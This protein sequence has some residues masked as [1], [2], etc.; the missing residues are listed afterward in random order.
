MDRNKAVAGEAKR[1][2]VEAYDSGFETIAYDTIKSAIEKEVT[3]EQIKDAAPEESFPP[4]VKHMLGELDDGKK[5]ALFALTHFLRTVGWSHEA[6]EAKLLEWN[7]KQKEPLKQTY[8]R[9]QLRYFKTQTA[10]LPPNCNNEAYYKGIGVCTPDHLCRTL[11]NPV[12]YTKRRL[13]NLQNI[14]KEKKKPKSEESA[15]KKPSNDEIV[16]G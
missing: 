3:Y 6:I 7:E 1:L 2:F 4:C 8:I 12:S 11:N 5:R 15:E 13:F 9:G 16:E 10:R 14:K